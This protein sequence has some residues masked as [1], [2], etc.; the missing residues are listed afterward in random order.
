M[1]AIK[2]FSEPCLDKQ[3][4]RAALHGG[5]D[6]NDVEE[7]HVAFAAFDLAHVRAVDSSGIGERFL[8]E[9]E[10]LSAG[11]H[12]FAQPQKRAFFVVVCRDS[13]HGENL[14]A[15]MPIGPRYLRTIC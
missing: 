11:A 5:S 4:R 14:L 10:R 2:P 9:V 7:C 8:G 1:S 13:C 12:S 6:P 3:V 15:R